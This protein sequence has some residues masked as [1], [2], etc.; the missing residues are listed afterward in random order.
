MDVEKI[1]KSGKYDLHTIDE[2]ILSSGDRTDWISLD[3]RARDKDGRYLKRF[4]MSFSPDETIGQ[5]MLAFIAREGETTASLKDLRN[6]LIGRDYVTLNL[7]NVKSGPKVEG[8]NYDE[9]MM[10]LELSPDFVR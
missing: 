6:R 3:I 9:S 7:D 4:T 5:D 1:V 8:I 10:W 2:V